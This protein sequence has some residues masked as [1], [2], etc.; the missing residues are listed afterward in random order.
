MDVAPEVRHSRD[1]LVALS[2]VRTRVAT[3][4]VV[5]VRAAVGCAWFIGVYEQREV[6]VDVVDEAVVQVAVVEA[7]FVLR[8]RFAE[9]R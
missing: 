5:I 1:A 3:D 8:T 6:R 9:V 2:A 4:V 7:V